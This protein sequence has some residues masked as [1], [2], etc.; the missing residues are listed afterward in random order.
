MII[1]AR[2]KSGLGS[3]NWA[4]LLLPALLCAIVWFYPKSVSSDQRATDLNVVC[5][6]EEV[7]DGNFIFKDYIIG[8]G[9]TQSDEKSYSGKYSSRVDKETKY[10]MSL[11][12]PAVA[13]NF[14]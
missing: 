6:A 14:R 3:F 7:V 11:S 5:D 10:G 1:K 4:F 13:S 2:K 8:N 12:I 9:I